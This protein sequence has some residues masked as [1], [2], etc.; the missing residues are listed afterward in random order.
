LLTTD[1]TRLPLDTVFADAGLQQRFL[2]L[3]TRRWNAVT[4]AL[5]TRVT[6]LEDPQA[7]QPEVVDVGSSLGQLWA[8]G[9]M[10]AVNAWPEEWAGPRNKAAQ[11]W[12]GTTLDL[13]QALTLDDKEVPTL[14]AFADAQDGPA[15]VSE[16]RMRA[17]GDAIWAVYNM[18][19]TWRA[20]GPRVQTVHAVAVPGRNDPC[21][22]GSGKKF[23]KCCGAG[24]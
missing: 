20:L 18:R 22:C 15:T 13:L 23:K 21:I 2:Q 16:Q 8:L 24:P 10:A 12:R 3:W 9:F 7:Y 17:F 14:A 5:D 1:G 4:R 6:S 19:E 11:H